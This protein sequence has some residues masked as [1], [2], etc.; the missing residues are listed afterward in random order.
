LKGGKLKSGKA[1]KEVTNPKHA[2]AIGLSRA[3]KEGAKVAPRKT[4]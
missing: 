4:T 3:R 1:G 2:V